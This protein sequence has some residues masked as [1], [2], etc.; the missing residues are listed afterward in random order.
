M[1]REFEIDGLNLAIPHGNG[2]TN[3]TEAFDV[4][5]IVVATVRLGVHVKVFLV[6]WEDRQS[7]RDLVVVADGNTRQCGLTG[8][9]HVE[10]RGDEMDQVAQRRYRMA[11]VW[12][13]RQNRPARRSAFRGDDPIVTTDVVAGINVLLFC[14]CLF[15]AVKRDGCLCE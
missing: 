9:D 14:D 13:V 11:T 5:T 6:D 8:T 12:V 2:F 4:A 10:V 1:A 3:R 7:E 15:N